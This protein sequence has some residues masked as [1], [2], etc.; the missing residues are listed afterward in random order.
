[1]FLKH[2]NYSQKGAHA[3]FLARKENLKD[4]LTPGEPFE[5]RIRLNQ[6]SL[7]DDSQ[8]KYFIICNSMEFNQI[9]LLFLLLLL[10]KNFNFL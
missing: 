7:I 3:R 6:W 1:M 4:F 9:I 5:L 8:R 2:I 10:L